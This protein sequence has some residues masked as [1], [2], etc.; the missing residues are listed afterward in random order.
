MGPTSGSTRWIL[1][2]T[3]SRMAIGR[4][5]RRPNGPVTPRTPNRALQ[6]STELLDLLRDRVEPRNNFGFGAASLPLSQCRTPNRALGS[7]SVVPTDGSSRRTEIPNFRTLTNVFRCPTRHAGRSWRTR[8]CWFGKNAAASLDSNREPAICRLAV[9]LRRHGP[10]FQQ[11]ENPRTIASR[12]HSA[13]LVGSTQEK[14][15]L[16]RPVRSGIAFG[17]PGR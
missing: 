13:S 2:T 1:R 8:P 14:T 12:S 4:R 6:V 15:T 7:T 11:P 9:A 17:R 16:D 3:L 5:R 10:K